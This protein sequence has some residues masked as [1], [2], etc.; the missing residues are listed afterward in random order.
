MS[1]LKCTSESELSFKKTK[2]RT[3]W[4]GTVWAEALE[5]GSPQNNTIKATY[6]ESS[7]VLG[8]NHVIASDYQNNGYK[9]KEPTSLVGS[10]LMLGDGSDCVCAF[11]SNKESNSDITEPV[12]EIISLSDLINN[13]DEGNAY[14][15]TNPF[16]SSYFAADPL[17]SISTLCSSSR[18]KKDFNFEPLY[19]ELDPMH[20]NSSIVAMR[21]SETDETCFVELQPV[22][23]F[24]PN[25]S[26]II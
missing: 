26:E 20:S 3:G 10:I 13:S 23:K 4:P 11:C 21:Q 16:S 17:P 25:C 1:G 9:N 2:G 18:K 15:A 5:N 8:N 12:S 19:N 22:T 24:R 7:Q 14:C 6:I